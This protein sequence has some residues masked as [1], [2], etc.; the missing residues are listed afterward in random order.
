[1]LSFAGIGCSRFVDLRDTG[2]LQPA[3][4]L[5]LLLESSELCMRRETR[6]DHLER[7][8]SPG[9]F[10]FRQV[11]DAHAAL[12]EHVQDLVV[13]DHIGHS[14]AACDLVRRREESFSR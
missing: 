5:R 4:H 3:E 14:G 10:L 2:V 7:Y 9:L 11:D 13:A 1:M 6:T 12:A 8:C